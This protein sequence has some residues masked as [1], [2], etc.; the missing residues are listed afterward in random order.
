M[1]LGSINRSA[2]QR[3]RSKRNA[4]ALIAG[5]TV[6]TVGPLPAATASASDVIG[7]KLYCFNGN[8]NWIPTMPYSVHENDYHGTMTT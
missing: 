6:A 5:S 1:R 3:R 7:N 4:I 2:V 8:T